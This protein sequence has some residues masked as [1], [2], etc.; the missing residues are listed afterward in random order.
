[1]H[2]KELFKAY[3][4]TYDTRCKLQ[5]QLPTFNIIAYGRNCLSYES[6]KTWNSLSS[7]I[8]QCS[9]RE[10]FKGHTGLEWTTL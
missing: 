3:H 2:I 7:T 8:K 6:A 4:T 1:M 5:M 10:V 9:N